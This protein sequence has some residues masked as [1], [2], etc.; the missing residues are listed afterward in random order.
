M[1]IFFV[2]VLSDFDLK[3]KQEL[4]PMAL[5]KGMMSMKSVPLIA[6]FFI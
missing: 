6:P 3:K 5:E 2:F 1:F 4:Q